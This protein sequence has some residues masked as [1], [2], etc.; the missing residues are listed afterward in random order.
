M[1]ICDSL[2][3]AKPRALFSFNRN[4]F[5]ISFSNQSLFASH[6]KW[7]FGNGIVSY[8]KNPSI[9]YPE[10]G[11]YL[12]SLTAYNECSNAANEITQV[13]SLC[14]SKDWDTLSKIEFLSGLQL[15]RFSDHLQ[16]IYKNC[17]WRSG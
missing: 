11:C 4:D 15:K 13:L 12:L 10:A 2:S 7:D 14:I 3:C 9:D 6:Y 17:D 1:A 16:F 8:D 5:T